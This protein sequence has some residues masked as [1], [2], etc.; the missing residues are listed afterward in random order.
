M[1]KM[2][3]YLIVICTI[4]LSWQLH[5]SS[6]K[7]TLRQE[8]AFLKALSLDHVPKLQDDRAKSNIPE[9]IRELYR[10]QSEQ[11]KTTQFRVPGRHVGA[12]NTLRTFDGKPL[13]GCGSGHSLC[14]LAFDLNTG[15]YQSE[16]VESAQLRVHWKPGKQYQKLESFRASVHDVY[17]LKNPHLSMMMD[18]KKIFHQDPQRDQGWY[19]F[20]VTP[21]LRRWLSSN[22]GV[23]GSSKPMLAVEK[24]LSTVV[25]EGIFSDAYLVVFSEDQ[26]HRENRLKRSA[27]SSSGRRHQSNR[28]HRRRTKKKK[29]HW[30]HCKRHSLYVDFAEVGWNDWIV[31][32]PGYDAHFCHGECHFPLAEHLNA[33]NHA[34]VQTMVNSVNPSAVPRACCIP[35]ELSP[36][37]MLYLDEYEKVVLKN[38]EDMV[39]ENCGCR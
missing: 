1:L 20:D 21:A 27:S 14:V 9:S 7:L 24:T 10:Q 30:T 29:G 38:Y 32:P 34:I 35:I 8:Q 33:T 37:S 26:K 11:D 2:K 15:V 17:K 12:S 22:D 39:I 28:S 18:T 6:A 4:V 31:A 25:P 13:G 19:E 36:I 23:S 5:C 3:Y 16:Q